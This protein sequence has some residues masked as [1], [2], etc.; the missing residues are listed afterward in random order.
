MRFIDLLKAD[1]QYPKY[2]QRLF[3]NIERPE[4][5][6]Q[7]LKNK[8]FLVKDSI[9]SSN[10]CLKGNLSGKFLNEKGFI[11]KTSIGEIV[12][13]KS[14]VIEDS[15]TSKN[16]VVKGPVA[17][18]KDVVIGRSTIIGPAFISEG[19]KIYD[20]RIRGGSNGSVY[21]GSNCT[22]WDH[23]VVNR[24]LIGENSLVHTC[25]VNDSIIGPNSNLGGA[26][27]HSYHKLPSSASRDDTK[28]DQRIILT[29]YSFGNKIKIPNPVTDEIV[30]T[31]TD[32]FGTIAGRKV[33]L[34]SGTIIYPGT[35]IGSEAKIHC[36]LPLVGYFPPKKE[37]SLFLSIRKYKNGKEKIELK[38]SMKSYLGRLLKT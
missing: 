30:H 11:R 4:Q 27:I 21:T 17:L 36:N 22:L 13:N 37:Y 31:E 34:S 28:L 18:G 24:S 9:N 33:W 2:H 14:F 5:M 15:F 25:N 10:S 23:T 29:N 35:I 7:M 12:V 6:A 38:G 32:H 1:L 19:S 3:N 20:S 8:D 16:V 26:R